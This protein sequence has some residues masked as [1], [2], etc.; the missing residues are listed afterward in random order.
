MKEEILLKEV[1]LYLMAWTLFILTILAI[2]TRRLHRFAK[3]YP[4]IF[5]PPHKNEDKQ[6]SEYRRH[7][8]NY[9]IIALSMPFLWI[10]GMVFIYFSFDSL[11]ACFQGKFLV[12]FSVLVIL[13]LATQIHRKPK[14]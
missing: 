12:V 9:S 13:F 8:N 2:L 5:Y 1:T 14:E 3:K 7:Y 4:G 10:I 11:M 6:L